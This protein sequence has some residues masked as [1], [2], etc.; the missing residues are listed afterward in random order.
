[1]LD[2]SGLG[3]TAPLPKYQV[4][5]PLFWHNGFSSTSTIVFEIHVHMA[6][7]MQCSVYFKKYNP[8]LR[9]R[10]CCEIKYTE[11]LAEQLDHY[12]ATTSKLSFPSLCCTDIV[13]KAQFKIIWKI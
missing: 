12:D 8:S 9:K 6:I 5:G 13:G 1:M 11:K 4:E 10:H 3:Y 7:A 2:I